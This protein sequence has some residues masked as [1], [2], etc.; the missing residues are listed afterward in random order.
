M[1][2]ESP[3]YRCVDGV[4]ELAKLDRAM[5]AVKLSDDLAGRGLERREQRRRAMPFVVPRSSLRLPRTHRQQG[6]RAVKCLNL[7]LLVDAQHDGVLGRMDI[8]PDDVADFL[9]QQRVRRQLER[10]DTMRLQAEGAP[11]PVYG[12]MIEAG[13]LR[14]RSNTPVA[15]TRGFR[16]QRPNDHPLDLL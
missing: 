12:H 13:S 6:L 11:D 15:C 16:F 9:D 5:P 2:V 4:Q 8:Q 3:R 7:R 1:H 10:L 14:H